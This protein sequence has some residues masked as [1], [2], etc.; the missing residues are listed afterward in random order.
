SP[1]LFEGSFSV[2]AQNG[3]FQ[4]LGKQSFDAILK[5]IRIREF[6]IAGNHT[7][8]MDA[9]LLYQERVVYQIDY[10]HRTCQKQELMDEF[11][12]IE[13]PDNS[14]LIGQVV[15]GSLSGPGEG[16]L[17]NSWAGDLPEVQ[18]WYVMTFTEFGCFPVG[19][20]YSVPKTDL[21]VS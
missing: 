17:A 13:I 11:H 4:G 16:V 7:E 1:P 5:R 20:L 15:L 6:V 10:K 8:V 14:T 2:V 21:I 9:L 18:G 3:N 19:V 12:P